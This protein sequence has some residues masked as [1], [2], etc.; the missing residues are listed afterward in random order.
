MSINLIIGPMFA[1]KTSMLLNRFKRYTIGGKKC[2]MIKY[3][4]DTRYDDTNV[5]THDGH[6][7]PA[8]CCSLLSEIESSYKLDIYDVICIDE[9][10][11]YEDA[12]EFCEKWANKG[13]IIEC[14]GLSGTFKRHPFPVISKLVP[15]CEDIQFLTAICI[16]SGQPASFSKLNIN[17]TSDDSAINIGGCDKYTA[18]DRIN[19]LK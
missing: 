11:F 6:K 17:S 15:L 2:L 13:K 3:K 18:V 1:G 19:W 14:S 9:I 10:Q 16:E 5:V 8:T 7:I 12:P 4:G